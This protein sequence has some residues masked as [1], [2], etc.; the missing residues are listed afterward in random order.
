M[1]SN[2]KEYAREYYLKNRTSTYDSSKL[3]CV[4]CNKTYKTNTLTR[5]LQSKKHKLNYELYTLKTRP[6]N[7]II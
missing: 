7:K 4:C 5:H 3:T 1:P 2:S 6:N